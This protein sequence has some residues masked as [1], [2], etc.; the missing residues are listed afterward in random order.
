ME[1][2]RPGMPSLDLNGQIHAEESCIGDPG[3]RTNTQPLSLEPTIYK[4]RRSLIY[5]VWKV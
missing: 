4:V 3:P 1:T 5:L 2:D